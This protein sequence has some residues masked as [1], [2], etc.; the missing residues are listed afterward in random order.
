MASNR[1]D[2]RNKLL[3]SHPMYKKKFM[4]RRGA[5][6]MRHYTTPSF[7]YPTSEDI[8]DLQ[9]L[10]H[11]WRTG[12]RFYKLSYT[13]YDTPELGWVIAMFNQRPTEAHMNLGDVI[14]IPTPLD[15]VMTMMEV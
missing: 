2:G 5:P 14:Y 12:D 13:Y 8:A 10:P 15:R 3:N 11:I 4:D 6:R 9:L 7:T 1:Y